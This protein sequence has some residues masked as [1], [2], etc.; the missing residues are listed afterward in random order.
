MSRQHAKFSLPSLWGNVSSW[1][2]LH[3]LRTT[4]LTFS[5]GIYLQ[6][7]GSTHGTFI[8][9]RRLHPKVDCTVNNGDVV[10]FGVK[11]TS[12][13]CKSENAQTSITGRSI[14]FI[15]ASITNPSYSELSRSGVPPSDLLATVE[16][17]QQV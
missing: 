6:D 15:Y 16:V 4:L 10:T 5:K 3:L 8:G 1:I 13:P 9:S 7:Y 2:R 11:I 12:G 17:S 14:P